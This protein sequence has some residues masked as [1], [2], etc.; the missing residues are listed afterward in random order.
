MAIENVG[1]EKLPNIY[2]K[3]VNLLDNDIKSFKVSIEMLIL[4][5]LVE[6]SFMWSEDPLL[7]DFVKFALVETENQN[8]IEELTTGDLLPMPS[9]IK[10]SPNFDEFSKVHVFGYGDLRKKEDIDDKHFTF[11]TELIKRN[12]IQNLTLFALSYLDHHEMS[13]FLGIKLTGVLSRYLGALTSE[14][15]MFLGELQKTS[16]AFKKPS[17]TLWSGPV[18]KIGNDWYSGSQTSPESIKLERMSVKNL[19]LSDLRITNFK[20]R[21]KS[22]RSDSTILSDLHYTFGDDADLFGTFS[23]DIRQF[24]LNRTLFGRKIYGMS[25]D[26]FQQAMN[27]IQIN[28]L[29]IRRRQVDF[30]RQTNRLGTASYSPKDILPYRV[31]ATLKDLEEI[32]LIDD[33]AIRTFSFSDLEMTH[34]SKGEFIYEI[35]STLID[36]TQSFVENIVNQIKA[37]L[38]TIKLEIRRLNL[39]ANYDYERNKIK[40]GVEIP[41]IISSLIDDYYKFLSMIKEIDQDKMK[42][43]SETKKSLF[44]K[45]TY[46]SQIGLLFQG[47]YEKLY[48]GIVRRFGV[49]PKEL[50]EGKASPSMAYPPNLIFYKKTFPDVIQ[51]NQTIGSYDVL[52]LQGDRKVLQITKSDFEARADKE[53]SRFFDRSKSVNSEDMLN[54]NEEVSSALRDLS[55]P[56][57][58]FMAPMKLDLEGQKMDISNLSDVDTDGLSYKFLMLKD[59]KEDKNYTTQTRP[60]NQSASKKAKKSLTK[61]PISKRVKSKKFNFNFRPVAIKINQ[62]GKNKNDYRESVDYLGQNSEFINIEN[63]LDNNIEAVDTQQSINRIKVSNEI[64]SKRSKKSFDIVEK[65]NVVE[66]F[67]RSKNF[68][69]LTLRKLPVSIKSIINSRSTAAKNNILE[70]DS[71]ILKSVDTKIA[72]EMIFHSNQKIEALVGYEK[73]IDGLTMLNRPIWGELTKEMMETKNKIFCRTKYSEIPQLD[74]ETAP[75]FKLPVKNSNFIIIGDGAGNRI[76]EIPDIIDQLPEVDAI[77]YTTSNIITQRGE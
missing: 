25:T 15:I 74:L 24:V 17:G 11:K 19:K 46:S 13:N 65:G 2:F 6:N 8:L 48:S 10:K 57:F 43:M 73:S 54:L 26:L 28:S 37:N 61:S 53:V 38:N 32:D 3:K 56:S 14:R 72:A 4:D 64:T 77:V 22:T 7:R 45:E 59:K 42:E 60:K 23:M 21:L 27:G 44:K 49:S 31:I 29:E 50:R 5:E 1:L 71:D 34:Q 58:L 30:K 18:H 76:P 20:T 67:M 47:E 70:E 35:H 66:K 68:S 16:F 12:E 33:E 52:D 55:T 39:I 40:D 69:P 36:N 63:N 9:L 51:F 62:L 41:I 75:E